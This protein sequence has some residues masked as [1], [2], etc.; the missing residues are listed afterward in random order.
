MLANGSTRVATVASLAA[1]GKSRV[2]LL[3]SWTLNPPPQ[4]DKSE[5]YVGLADAFGQLKATEAI[6][7]LISNISLNRYPYVSPNTW[8][9]TPEVVQERLACARALIQIGPEA[10]RALISAF[11]DGLSAEDRLAAI[12]VISRIKGVPEARGFLLSAFGQINQER[13]LVE[14]GLKLIANWKRPSAGHF[15]REGSKW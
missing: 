3:I 1:S 4:V 12:F 14:E 9:K 6:P 13:H 11:H 15:E 10:S 7:F 2:P 5:L 8:L